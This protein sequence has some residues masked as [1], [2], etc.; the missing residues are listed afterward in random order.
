MEIVYKKA[1]EIK[2]SAYNPREITDSEFEKLKQS[3]SEFGFVE[4]IVINNDNEII[5]GHMRLK[6]GLAIGMTDF[7]CIVI[8]VTGDKAKLLNLA[9]N[10]ISGR[11]D[12]QKLGELITSLADSK[13]SLG[14]SGFDEW[15]LAYYNLGD[16]PLGDE[17]K[18]NEKLLDPNNISLPNKCPK[19]GYEY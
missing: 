1:G 10:R 13:F 19:C 2:E 9:L 18:I 16:K 5:G 8:D 11:W 15:E 4:P 7:P 14:L 17:G 3:L 12:V 6:A